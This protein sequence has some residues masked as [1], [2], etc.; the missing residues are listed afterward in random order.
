VRAN[1]KIYHEDLQ[2]ANLVRN[3]H[4]AKSISDGGWAA[5]LSIL[6]FKAACAG[7]SVVVSP[8]Y[9]SQTCSGCG[10]VG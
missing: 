9:T 6:S 5:F 8:G 2:T 3:H 10:R 7:C 1:A 4:L